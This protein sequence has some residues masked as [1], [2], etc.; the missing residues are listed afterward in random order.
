MVLF[1]HFI[2][3]FHDT[4][5]YFHF[6]FSLLLFTLTQSNT[7]ELFTFLMRISTDCMKLSIDVEHRFTYIFLLI[8][9]EDKHKFHV[10]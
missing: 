1:A 3:H 5:I 7:N 8:I 9:M 10:E 4:D 6:F 2:Y